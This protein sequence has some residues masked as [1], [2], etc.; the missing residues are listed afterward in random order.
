MAGS[1]DSDSSRTFSND[2]GSGS[3]KS[4]GTNSRA[5]DHAA[6][7]ARRDSRIDI[8]DSD[9]LSEFKEK[10]FGFGD[11]ENPIDLAENEGESGPPLSSSH[12]LNLDAL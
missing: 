7:A 10:L 1:S 11:E 3:R 5:P 12:L 9:D 8:T 2:S 4:S 6:N